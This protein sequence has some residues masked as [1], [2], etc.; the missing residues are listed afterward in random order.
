MNVNNNVFFILIKWNKF[1][2]LIDNKKI[3]DENLHNFGL[4]LMKQIYLLDKPLTGVD[5]IKQ[6]VY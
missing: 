2:R 6:Q 5:I 3:S 1:Y 4:N